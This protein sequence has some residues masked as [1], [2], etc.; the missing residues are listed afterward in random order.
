MKTSGMRLT[1]KS[2]R[3]LRRIFFLVASLIS[4]WIMMADWLFW[5]DIRPSMVTHIRNL[6]SAFNP[7]KVY[8]HTPGAVGS[9]LCCS[10]RGAVGGSV[11]C[12]RAT[13]YGIEGGERAL[14]IHSPHRQFL[15]AWDSNSQP[16]DYESDS[17]TIRSQICDDAFHTFLGLD[18]VIYKAVI[19]KVTNRPIF[20]KNTSNCVSKTNEAFTGL[21]RHG[22]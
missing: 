16:F 22:G 3:C 9:H 8:R 10:A 20:I 21:E 15:L 18:S 4:G 12:S 17:I 5:R 6:C 19:G 14:Y 2:V 13:R 1:H 7:S 11:P